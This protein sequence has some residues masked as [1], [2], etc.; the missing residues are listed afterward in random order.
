MDKSKQLYLEEFTHKK[1]FFL[2]PV[3]VPE[4]QFQEYEVLKYSNIWILDT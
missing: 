3:E 2:H 1:K 4:F